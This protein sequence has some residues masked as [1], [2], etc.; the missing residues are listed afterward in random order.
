MLLLLL[1][2]IAGDGWSTGPLARDVAA[3]YE[4][5]LRGCAPEW[6]PLPVQYA[7]YTLW[8]QDLLGDATDPDRVLSRQLAYWREQL[9]GIPEQLELPFDRSRPAVASYQGGHL[10]FELDADLH[11]RL[12]DVARDAGVTVFMV[13]QAGMATL[14]SR[15]GAGTDIVLG[16][17]IAG[18]T[19]AALDDLV[20]FF[21]NTLVLRTD[22]SGD[23]S[24]AEL[25]QRVRAT[26]L[27]AYTHQDVPFE[28]LVEALA[29][30]RS[31]AHQPLFQVMF[32]LQNAP[33]GEFELP[34]LHLGIE[35][36]G[37][38]VS[39]V[40]LSVNLV[41]R[42]RD[43]GTPSGL[44][45]VVEYATDL[46]D[47]QTVQALMR[48]LTSVLE[49]A[50]ADP[51]TAL[52]DMEV[53]LPDERHRIV[54][55]WNDTAAEL[56]QESLPDLF[57][58]QAARTPDAVAAVCGETSLSYRE[59]NA[60]AHRLARYLVGR[61]VGPETVV[62]VAMERTTELLVALL[63]VLKAGGT[64]LPVD[65]GYPAERIAFMLADARPA[66]LLTAGELADTLPGFGIEQVVVADAPAG[67]R[68]PEQP[69]QARRRPGDLAYLM[70]TSG[71]TGTP[72]GVGVAHRDVV[73][74]ATDKQVADEASGRMLLVAP[75]TFD[76]CNYELWAPLLHG[77][78]VVMAPAGEV[79][80][81]VVRKL[82]LEHRVTVVQLT[83][84]LF[85][86]VADEDPSCLTSVR[87]VLVGGDVVP[88]FAVRQILAACP[89]LA[90]S[91]TYGPTETTT[92]STRH[93][94]PPHAVVPDVVP[95]GRPLDH[96]KLY[97]L[98][99]ALRPVPPGVTG[100]L[101]I[102]GPGL[103]RGYAGRAALT[104]ERFVASPFTAGG[105]MY[106]TGD[107]VKWTGGGELV[108]CGRADDQVKIRGFRIEPGEVETVLCDHPEVSHAV[109]V[110]RED[111]PGDKRLVAYVVPEGPDP[112]PAALRSWIQGRLPEFM[113]PSAVLTLARVP[114]TAN[115]KLDRQALPAPDFSAAA[116][117][118]SRAPRTPREEVLHGLFAEVLG[119]ERLGVSDSFFELGGHSL[120]ATRLA[121]RVRSALGVELPVR[122]VFETPTVAG[123]AA[124]LEHS[125]SR[126]RL[127]LRPAPRP[128]AVPLSPAQRRLWFLNQLEGPSATY[129]MPMALRLTGRLDVVA[130]R[131][132][133]GDL[134]GR[135]EVLRTVFPMA[136]GIPR[137]EVRD[138]GEA[139]P[140]LVVTR[141]SEQNL[142]EAIATEC[143]RGFD[144][145]AELPSRA[146]L[147]V[148]GPDTHVL[149]L[150]VHHIAGD[151]WSSGPLARDLS[152]AYE[153]R[154][155]GQAPDWAPLP[156]QYADYTLWHQQLIGDES[157]PESPA[158]R[159]MAYWR[160]ELDALPEELSLPFDRSRPAASSYRGGH[161]R[162]EFDADLHRRLLRLAQGGGTTLFMVLQAG[163]A[164]LLS[165]LGA[166]EDIP[167]GTPVAGRTDEAL[168]DLVG[169]FVNTLVLRTDVSGD[170][171]FRQLLGRV[172]ETAL[173][174]YAHQD[175]PFERLV[176][177]LNP[178]R[179]ASRH[180]LFQI[181]LALQNNASAELNLPG[182]SVRPEPITTG[183]SRFDLMFSLAE[184][185]T[186]DGAPAGVEALAEYSG[187][188]FD[189]ATVEGIAERLVRVLEQVTADPDV[190]VRQVGVLSPTERRRIL[191][192]GPDGAVPV[193]TATL[194]ELFEAQVE[195]SP[196]ARAV[197]FGTEAVTYRELDARANRM[198]RYLV[199]RGVG[200]ESLVAVALPRSAD[201]VVALLAVLK[202]GGACVPVDPQYPAERIGFVLA[203]AAPVLTLT[204]TATAAVLPESDVDT[205][206]VDEEAT[207]AL[208]AGLPDDA[209]SDAE[210][211][212]PLRSD[213]PAYV[214]YTSGSTGTPK[215]VLVPHQNVVRLFGATDGW[216][217]YTS[218]DVWTMFHS[219]AFDFSVWE[220]W[221]PLLHGGRLVV[222]PYAVSRSPEEFL[223]LLVRERVT[224][225]SQTPSAF[226][227]LMDADRAEP[228]LSRGLALRAVVFG[229]E[230]LDFA[231]LG[232][233]Y[234]R[235]AD[236]DP[237]LVNMYGITET[238]VHVS[239]LAV[240]R[241]SAERRIGSVIGRGIPDLRTFVLDAGLGPVP[242]GV[243]GELYVAGAGL[244]RGY[245]R[246]AGL[247]AERFVACPYEP[248][249]R[250]YRTGDL[251]KWTADG[252][253]VYC[254]R[255]DEQVKIRGFRIEPGEIE[256]V[257]SGHPGVAQAVV[258]ARE[259]NTG[260]K[261]LVGYVVPTEAAT[262][263]PELLRAYVA[264]VLPEFMVPA[265]IVVIDQV[266]LTSSGKVDRRLLP[267]PD[268]S[269]TAGSTRRPR[270]PREEVLCGLFAEVLGLDEVGAEDEFFALG[271]DSIVSI[272]LVA[273]ARAAGLL[274][275]PL[276]IF[277]YR[278]VAAL[279]AAAGDVDDSV[280]T[281]PAG[282]GIGEVPATPIVEW[283]RE[284]NGAIDAFSQSMLLRVPAGLGEQRL[285]EALQAV[286]DRH[287][288]LR[289]SLAVPSDDTWRLSVGPVG[290]VRAVD[291]VS[292]VDVTG[293]DDAALHA[294]TG[295][296]GRA[297]QEE[298]DPAAGVMVRAVWFDAGCESPGRLLLIVH[299]LA[300]DGVSWRILV[301]DLARAWEAVAAG[302]T[303]ALEPVG[304][305]FRRWARDLVAA[306]TGPVHTS[307][308]P[309]WKN[310]LSGAEPPLTDR[311][312]DPER[313]VV[314]STAY[315]TM[316]LPV[317]TTT[318]VL[319]H[320]PSAFNA[321][322]NDVL[323]TG[324]AVAITQWRSRHDR[325]AGSAVRIAV[326]GHGREEQAVPGA[327]LSRTVG[328][329][330]SLYPVRLDP[331]EVDWTEVQ[332]GGQGLGRALKQVKEQL[333]AVPG[334]GL[335][336]GLL[337]YLNPETAPGLADLPTPE[338]GFNYL[339]RMG[340][341]GDA[342]TG[343][344]TPALEAA[345]LGV[346]LAPDTPVAHALEINA[347]AR[348]TAEGPA[349]TATWSWPSG[350]LSEDEVR[351]L[352]GIWFEV[353]EALVRHSEDP[354]AGGLTPSDA[355]LAGLSQDEIDE[356][357]DGMYYDEP[358]AGGEWTK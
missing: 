330:T 23:P 75:H 329:F 152:Q 112:D 290:A 110:A 209:L 252:Q 67:D 177:V 334:N 235:H 18:R 62:A 260:D 165:R 256:T 81:A 109:V 332:T 84:G 255:A 157:D 31:L 339:G 211:V 124:W 5:R 299:H 349:L 57:E 88:G 51:E 241:E 43:D 39:R 314:S 158:G 133:L 82:L 148:L 161:I 269:P 160:A 249:R 123:L 353:L 101:Y 343:H 127:P 258:A 207:A 30:A 64:Y 106:R 11:G 265:A 187:D 100:E 92:F 95:I 151:G 13:L 118:G 15:L 86:V 322:V 120:L 3:A 149:V 259:G 49:Q 136:D 111:Q 181:M 344:W 167:V 317:S 137:Q 34:G 107:L 104:A 248:G 225:L 102:A 196:E 200:P 14:L 33:A 283:L 96:R 325:G 103:A 93:D 193:P 296:R 238:T 146:R 16:A 319:T 87:K 90:V 264:G 61:G 263:E 306:A 253:L 287:D 281:E 210:R 274:L 311:G 214:I 226:Y 145:S 304:T 201:L 270:T 279:A 243:V 7:D 315:V 326:E 216:F 357:E 244:A 240:D 266:P 6:A 32:G 99:E 194:P 70:Y 121:S 46:F 221:G 333:R 230:A 192:Q 223:R 56:P 135:H 202:A 173:A 85:R 17:P 48:R 327:E 141:T 164:A 28:H 140:E 305:S 215:G 286:L 114:L 65:P 171:T 73:A 168:D 282:A 272:Q 302:R 208:V 27:D 41:E 68:Q 289:M 309:Y 320:V 197:A 42:H 261:L 198:A 195:R 233:W 352:A 228:E 268:F 45:G 60:R 169:F 24:F 128:D 341:A 2:H 184:R 254:G 291:C 12:V 310:A 94:I 276:D 36:V 232:D 132:A 176:E 213:H 22:T 122:T 257:L 8:Q 204:D 316:R 131:A 346:G 50:V 356:F 117:A 242:P 217:H 288:A 183:T 328:W 205:L 236:T 78:T 91:V 331:G 179:S 153:A 55:E 350:L 156:V 227:Q 154:G 52:G 26:V 285:A 247:T 220:L 159:Q 277:T 143:A 298:L 38:G 358:D 155:R 162:F 150:V 25:L 71:S 9:S 301:P 129:N 37:T 355:R 234:A 251:A 166:G 63:G 294:V 219:F 324:L 89:D 72:K 40:D 47:P 293:L 218:D 44:Q 138:P 250:M 54:Q 231:R 69:L 59:L 321:G 21:V 180:P 53:L 116:A 338:V 292:R 77:G 199:G 267:A 308:L 19:D 245:V 222:V 229:G 284:R 307:H 273:R 275:S 323:L 1:H 345:E 4:A 224:V 212:G 172:R 20:G 280:M 139:E 295:E 175:V 237:V 189:R 130:L 312:V 182:L 354:D 335:G 76:A 119:V 83:A 303:V 347:M 142:A 134:M 80:V 58:Q 340:S 170:P 29:P 186:D 318:A 163:L 185:H 342:E 336:Y 144:L 262:A 74:F 188:L 337:R 246:R 239:H 66:L 174:A 190:P 348:E 105:R 278:T 300:V 147:F 79:D 113:V 191:E 10:P 126:A 206:V 313:D 297:A 178:V 98:D 115:G 35:P 125:G 108:F 351:E 97:V 271:G 203:D